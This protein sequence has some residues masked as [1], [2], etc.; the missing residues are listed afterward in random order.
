MANLPH[1]P[2]PEVDYRQLRLS[3]LNTPA[4]RHL[5]LLLYWPLFGLLFYIAEWVYQPAAFFPMHCALD[6]VIPFCE[7]FLIPYLFWFVF[8]VGMHLYTLLYDVNAFRKM[9]Y[10]IIFTYSAALIMFYLFPTCQNLRP[11]V[12]PR[13]NLL[14]RMMGEFYQCD[15]STNVCPSLHVVGSMAVVF[16]AWQTRRLQ[17]RGW[18]WAFGVTG[19][20]ISISTVFVKQHSIL[21]VLTAVPLCAAGYVLFFRT[22]SLPTPGVS[23]LPR[24]TQR[25]FQVK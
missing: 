19:V 7:V 15:T 12:F 25:R 10:F 4:F 22:A 21:D 17:S 24:C 13:D 9:M 8:L 20:L 23:S 16:A 11:A 1:L 18:K 14:T 2:P 5:Y 3:N 6:D